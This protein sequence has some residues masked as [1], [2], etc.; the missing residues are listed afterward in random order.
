VVNM[1]QLARGNSISECERSVENMKKR[2]WTPI[3]EVKL[4]NSLAY[5]GGEASYV[6]VMELPDDNNKSK[7]KAHR[8]NN[9]LPIIR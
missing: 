4:D 6:V 7:N 3:T 9:N 5:S 1:R 8:W 2:G